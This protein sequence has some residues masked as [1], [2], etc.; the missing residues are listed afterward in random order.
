MKQ[1]WLV[2]LKT[3]PQDKV[4]TDSA[5]R[6]TLFKGH[7]SNME[8]LHAGG[9]LKVAGPFGKNDFTWRGL[10]ILDCAT[11]ED[12]EAHVKT[13]PAV[14]AGIFIFDIVPWYGEPSGSFKP[15]KPEKKSE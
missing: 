15:G 9:V 11:R 6:S 3:G 5:E 14:G 7:F 2:V 1:F 13:D 10:F 4:I 8:R 12:A